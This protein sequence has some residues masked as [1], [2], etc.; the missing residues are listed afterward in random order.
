M[1]IT[2]FRGYLGNLDVGGNKGPFKEFNSVKETGITKFLLLNKEQ[3]IFIL[4]FK[5][6]GAVNSINENS[7]KISIYFNVQRLTN[8]KN[9]S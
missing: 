7:I 6:K 8:K 5:L 9:I 1:K 3:F 2:F 4:F